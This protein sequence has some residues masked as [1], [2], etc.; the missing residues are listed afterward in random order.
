LQEATC[1][2]LSWTVRP[3]RKWRRGKGCYVL[4]ESEDIDLK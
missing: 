4:S 2:P 1:S 3:D